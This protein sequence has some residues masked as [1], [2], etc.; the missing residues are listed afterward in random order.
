MSLSPRGTLATSGPSLIT[1]HNLHSP[2][3]PT[4]VPV[5]LK[6]YPIRTLAHHPT[7]LTH[8][9]LERLALCRLSSLSF[10]PSL[11]L[12]RRTPSSVMLLM[13]HLPGV[14]LHHL[15]L[16]LSQ[17]DAFPILNALLPALRAMHLAGIV[18]ADLA[19]RNIL[20]HAPTRAIYIVDFGLCWIEGEQEGQQTANITPPE[21][22][23]GPWTD[24][25]ALGNIVA[26]LMGEENTHFVTKCKAHWTD[27]F[28]KNM[29]SNWARV[30]DYDQ[31]EKEMRTYLRP[32]T[33]KQVD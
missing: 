18:H 29:D 15:P 10:F 2:L 14:P 22:N 24:I 28:V 27:R 1:L 4:P 13:S 5:L 21:H 23:V 30:I 19:L 12:S 6:T 9:R 8:L 20:W 25:W 32:T 7:L 11:L 26:Q 3:H 33:S 31:M 16:P 17:S